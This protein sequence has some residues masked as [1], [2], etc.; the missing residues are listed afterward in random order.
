M[1]NSL[2]LKVI[3]SLKL[4]KNV[5]HDFH[6]MTSFHDLI[7]SLFQSAKDQTKSDWMT[8]IRPVT[9]TEASNLMAVQ[10]QNQVKRI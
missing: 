9:N 10:L 8:L 3:L 5:F 6:F 4:S 7:I 1:E 2:P